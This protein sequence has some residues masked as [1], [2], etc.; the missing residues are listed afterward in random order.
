MEIPQDVV[1]H[2]TI[3]FAYV[4]FC[5]MDSV[6]CVRFSFA[7]VDFISCVRHCIFVCDC[8]WRVTLY[9]ELY[10]G[11]YFLLSVE[12]DENEKEKIRE[13]LNEMQSCYRLLWRL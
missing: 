4:L 1:P 2:S 8:V 10:D 12:D 5:L 7:D 3:F 6:F 13:G 9:V 11:Y